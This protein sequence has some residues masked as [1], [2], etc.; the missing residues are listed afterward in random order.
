MRAK[1]WGYLIGAAVLA[2][3][4][5][6]FR[7]QAPLVFFVL[8]DA[9]IPEAFR[10]QVPL[11]PGRPQVDPVQL[12][13][14]QKKTAMEVLK[15]GDAE[16]LEGF[17]KGL[18]RFHAVIGLPA[19][20]DA[21][22]AFWEKGLRGHGPDDEFDDLTWA[23]RSYLATGPR[24][25]PPAPGMVPPSD[26]AS[27]PASKPTPTVG[28]TAPAPSL[29]LVEIQNGCGITGAADWVARRLKGVHAQVV[30]TGNADN[31]RY[32][33]TLL[34]TNLSSSPALEEVLD[35]LGLDASRVEGLA[36]PIPGVDAV[37]VVGKDF[38]KLK[39]KWRERDRHGK[40]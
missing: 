6:A 31:F 12:D 5:L 20:E 16:R 3:C 27:A 33:R 36:T 9:E 11:G 38:P 22:P 17:A 37:I 7:S 4:F 10:V 39:E 24:P 29:L 2:G 23:D 30:G 40:K 13:A 15:S 8:R 1:I 14:G 19:V 18:G 35:R 21:W 28:T 26:Q 34:R 32:P 25:A